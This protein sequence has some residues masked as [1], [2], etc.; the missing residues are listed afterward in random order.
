MFSF[1]CSDRK[2]RLCKHTWAVP[3]SHSPPSWLGIVLCNHQRKYRTSF[4]PLTMMMNEIISLPAPLALH[5][6]GF[7]LS[8]FN[9][10]VSLCWM[11]QGV[12]L[13]TTKTCII[14]MAANP[15]FRLSWRWVSRKKQKHEKTTEK[16]LSNHSVCVVFLCANDD[17]R[18]KPR[19]LRLHLVKFFAMAARVCLRFRFHTLAA[20]RPSRREWQSFT[21]LEVIFMAQIVEGWRNFSSE[22]ETNCWEHCWQIPVDSLSHNLLA[23]ILQQLC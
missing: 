6:I 20:G 10:Q 9:T 15:S 11:E 19:E 4:T 17:S 18:L 23:R 7:S 12:K 2:R 21:R 8:F 5:D 22:E 13:W 1:Y 3:P 16:V 14:L